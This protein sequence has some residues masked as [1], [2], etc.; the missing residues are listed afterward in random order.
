M[1][2]HF[3]DEFVRFIL[4]SQCYLELTQ[5]Y[6]NLIFNISEHLLTSIGNF[7]TTFDIFLYQK[8]SFVTINHFVS[9]VSP[10]MIC[11]SD[12]KKFINLTSHG[13]PEK[14]DEINI[15]SVTR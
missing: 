5:N 13:E 3:F 7:P 11:L 12:F 9:F 8:V 10:F 4:L 6:K 14:L 15:V 2:L 1:L